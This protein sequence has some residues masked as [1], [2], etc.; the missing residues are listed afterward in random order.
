MSQHLHGMRFA[1][2]IALSLL[3][4]CASQ[5]DGVRPDYA[6]GS[7]ADGIVTM[8]S[9]GTLYNPVSPDWREAADTASRRCRSWGYRDGPATFAGWQEA[10]RI[11]DRHGRCFRTVVTRFYSCSG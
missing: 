7:R 5:P 6:G 9:T 2:V 4:A 8:A 1:L 11:Y 3:S 10:C